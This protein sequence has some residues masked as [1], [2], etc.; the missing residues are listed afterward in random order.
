MLF[1]K[2]FPFHF[3]EYLWLITITKSYNLAETPK[4]SPIIKKQN[5]QDNKKETKTDLN[6]PLHHKGCSTFW[7]MNVT[8][9]EDRKVLKPTIW[10]IWSA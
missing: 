10:S 1:G 7:L 5:E 8:Y 3:Q 2:R 4:A 6:L 9:D